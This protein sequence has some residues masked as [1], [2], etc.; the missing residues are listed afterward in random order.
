M[1]NLAFLSLILMVLTVSFVSTPPKWVKSFGSDTGYDKNK[2]IIGFGISDDKGG[3]SKNFE[4]AKAHALRD[5]A[6][7]IK[8]KIVSTLELEEKEVNDD[9]Q[10]MSKMNIQTTVNLDLTGIE[11]YEKYYDS[12]SGIY[13]ALCVISKDKL[14]NNIYS[15]NKKLAD[16]YRSKSYIIDRLIIGQNFEKASEEYNSLIELLDKLNQNY[17]LLNYLKDGKTDLAELY[18]FYKIKSDIYGKLKFNEVQNFDDLAKQILRPFNEMSLKSKIF[19]IIPA[20]YKTTTISSEFFNYL[21][22]YLTAYLQKIGAQCKERDDGSID[23][24]FKGSFYD[25]KKGYKVLYS[26]TDVKSMLKVGLSEVDLSK[27]FVDNSGL[28]IL[29]D[30]IDVA[31]NDNKIFNQAVNEKDGV[32]LKVWTNKGSEDLVFKNGEEV[33]FYVM[34]NKS[35]YLSILYH[36]SGKNRLRTPLVENYYIPPDMI[37]KP[38]KIEPGFVV[39]PPFGSE[40]A[41]IFFSTIPQ[42]KFLTVTANIDGEEYK[43]LSGDYKEFIINKRGMKSIQ[44]EEKAETFITIT[45][46]EK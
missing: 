33:N 15:E 31:L 9:A 14:Y 8:T 3:N 26:L 25:T 6:G 4:S 39:Y 40:T 30:N 21:K 11:T 43:V 35:G 17:L 44:K 24:V 38:V 34:V 5:A 29:P 10:S 37:Y 13:Y 1:K 46:I 41:Q 32:D 45:T 7:L 12:K 18:D 16:D 22:E 2:Y 36:L 20:Y 28:K 23:Y 19:Y 27:D 42:D